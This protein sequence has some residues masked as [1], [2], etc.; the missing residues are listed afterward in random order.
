MKRRE[1]ITLLGGAA[2]AWPM[3]A[4]AQQPA[5]PVVGFLGSA[6]PQGYAR[7]IAS[8][9]QG[10]SESG[11]TEGRNLAAEY[12]WANEQYERLPALAAELV[13]RQ[14]AVI[15]T[16][17]GGQSA[18]AAK[19]ATSIIPIV[20]ATGSDPVKQG[21]VASLNR[22]GG[23]VTGVS[24]YSNA[25]AP[26]RLEI[27]REIVLKASMIAMLMNPRSPSVE[28]DV[29]EM[30]SAAQGVGVEFVVVYAADEREFESAVAMAAQQQAG[31]LIVHNDAL[32]ASRAREVVA[33]AAQYALPTIYAARSWSEVGGL[34]SY[35]NNVYDMLRHAG[36]YTARILKGERPPDLPVVM[37]VKFDLVIN[38]KTAKALGLTVPDTVLARADEVIE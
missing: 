1:F 21:L 26:K 28:S 13:H 18:M 8:V 27:L 22:P 29:R 12:R 24:F 37:P 33:L 6:T 16:T 10:L 5:K 2:A 11:F 3:A 35:G 30:Q 31:A 32:F 34:I 19:A 20:F 36:I 23:N 14:V 9:W 17:G 25:L 15:V 38:L 7:F 4:R